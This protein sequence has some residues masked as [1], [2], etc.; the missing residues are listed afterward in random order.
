MKFLF[1]LLLC[2]PVFS[3]EVVS[4]KVSYEK[5]EALKEAAYENN[6]QNDYILGKGKVKEKATLTIKQLNLEA[7]KYYDELV[8]NYPNSEYYAYALSEKASIEYWYKS[9]SEAR[10]SYMKILSL[11]NYN[12]YKNQALIMLATI[13]IEEKNYSQA[14]NYLDESKKYHKFYTCGN[15]IKRDKT[16]LERLYKQANDGLKK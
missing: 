4:D 3:Q 6:L 9:H 12:Y 1:L 11:T 10:E 14:I 8:K 5:G 16:I 15:E 2:F 13:A 7:F